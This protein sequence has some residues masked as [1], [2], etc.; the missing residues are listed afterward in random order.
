MNKFE[1]CEK[2]G[3]TLIFSLLLTHSDLAF[4]SQ[5]TRPQIESKK[6]IEVKI[7]AQISDAYGCEAYAAGYA[8][9]RTKQ[10]Y[11][12]ICG[13]SNRKNLSLYVAKTN[14]APEKSEREKV[15]IENVSFKNGI[16]TAARGRDTY[17]LTPKVFSL[18]RDG[19]ILIKET[20][21]KYTNLSR[22][23]QDRSKI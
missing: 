5:S 12:A 23:K 14:E 10:H 17:V 9:A 6:P 18:R 11:I 19:K 16:Y 21:V 8:I 1:L 15:Q 7:Q 4:S 22:G 3:L 20:V 13:G 2:I